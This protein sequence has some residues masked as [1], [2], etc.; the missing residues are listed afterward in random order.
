M[1]FE[2]SKR[3]VP[4]DV[5]MGFSRQLSV[6]I[7]A[8]IPILEAMEIILDETSDKTFKKALVDMIDGLAGRV[9]PSQ[10]PPRRHPKAFP[11]SLTSGIL[12]LC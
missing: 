3:R 11:L 7:S 8:G 9:T 1:A 12:E 2:I 4:R 10:P 5:V 6:F